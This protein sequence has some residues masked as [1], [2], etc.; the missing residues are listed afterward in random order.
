[1]ITNQG[2]RIEKSKVPQEILDKLIVKKSVAANFADNVEEYNILRES[3]KYYYLPRFFGIK[4]LG[5][6]PIKIPYQK[7]SATFKGTLR[8]QQQQIMNII[9]PKLLKTHG[10]VIKL[11]CGYGK[12]I[13][14]LYILCQLKVKTLIIVGKEF[15]LN[16]WIERIKEFITEYSNE[17]IQKEGETIHNTI[18]VLQQKRIET[19]HDIV[20]A[21]IQSLALKNYSREQ[22]NNFGLIISDECH[23]IAAQKFCNAFDKLNAKYIIGL[24]ATPKRKDGLSRIINWYLGDFLYK[25]D[26][27]ENKTAEIYRI[28]Y[29]SDD[30]LFRE[31]VLTRNGQSF[32]SV[33][34][35]LT[36]ISKIKERNDILLNIL[37][38]YSTLDR[39]ILVL[40]DRIDHLRYL[41][42]NFIK[43][44]NN[45]IKTGLYIGSTPEDERNRI[46]VECKIIFGSVALAQEGLDIKRLDTL[47]FATPQKDIVQSIGR[48]MRQQK[49]NSH[50]IE[51]AD[52]LGLFCRYTHARD[53][54]Y[55]KNNYQIK[56]IT[57]TPEILDKIKNDFNE[58]FGDK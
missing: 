39:N 6:V 44:S 3:E 58:L 53:V 43:L 27:E 2:Y 29:V 45:T 52:D 22:L 7:I 49:I 21:T 36:N 41:Q 4:E 32:S 35:M 20:I 33:P 31:E 5:N 30:P 25:L 23:H 57:Y 55:R 8:G 16:Q 54:I 38:Y 10:G 50:I 18:G 28:N 15:L 26:C 12:T 40:S 46:S 47:L 51:I 34:K 37:I 42:A 17:N 13:L 1:M 9:M 14:A 48:V 56:E 19:D 11:P 24:S